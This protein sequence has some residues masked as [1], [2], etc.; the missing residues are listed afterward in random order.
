MGCTNFNT[1]QVKVSPRMLS[2]RENI[3]F[4]YMCIQTAPY[5]LKLYRDKN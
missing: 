3:F 1:A 4:K 5:V 2:T